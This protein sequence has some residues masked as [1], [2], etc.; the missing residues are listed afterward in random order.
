MN[1]SWKLLKIKY[2]VYQ[3]TWERLDAKYLK[4][5]FWGAGGYGVYIL[6]YTGSEFFGW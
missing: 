5:N 4:K 6:L 3:E 1:F 2:I